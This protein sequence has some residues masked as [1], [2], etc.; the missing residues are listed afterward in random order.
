MLLVVTMGSVI[1]FHHNLLVRHL[2]VR[3][4]PPVSELVPRGLIRFQMGGPFYVVGSDD[5]LS[6]WAPP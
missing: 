5:G 3:E 6:Y 4:A 2:L 1:G